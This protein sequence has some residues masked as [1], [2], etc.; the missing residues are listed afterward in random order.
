MQ[1]LQLDF[2]RIQAQADVPEKEDQGKDK[3]NKACGKEYL[4]Q[5]DQLDVE[6]ECREEHQHDGTDE[7]HADGNQSDGGL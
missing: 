4:D 3:A 1:L 7:K 5:G 2:E 6:G